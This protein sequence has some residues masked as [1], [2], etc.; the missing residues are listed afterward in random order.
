M[1]AR[2]HP[3]LDSAVDIPAPVSPGFHIEGRPR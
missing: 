1:T 3:N 2:T